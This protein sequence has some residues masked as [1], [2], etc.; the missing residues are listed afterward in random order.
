MGNVVEWKHIQ[1]LPLGYEV[2]TEGQ[3]RIN[4]GDSF[5]YP[6]VGKSKSGS[7]VNLQGKS[8]RIHKLVASAFLNEPERTS[9]KY[10][11]RHVDGDVHNN[12]VSNLEWV[13]Y[14]DN[15]K[16]GY[17][18]GRLK[19]K[20]V[21]CMETNT[22]YATLVSAELHLG[23]PRNI[24]MNSISK[25]TIC[26]GYHF[27]YVA[28]HEAELDPSVNIVSTSMTEAIQQSTSMKSIQEFRTWIQEENQKHRRINFL[29][30]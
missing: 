21:M 12:S 23:I 27:Q 18:S 6:N 3:V 10:M 13:S 30:I 7:T 25:N 9:A 17:Q 2:S 20:S 22:V 28:L 8:Y 14:S 29:K 19:G 24:I 1:N 15:V 16:E 5:I 11:I 26:F 4:Y